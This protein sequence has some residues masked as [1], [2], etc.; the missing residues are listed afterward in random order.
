MKGKLIKWLS[1][2]LCAFMV[3]AC[4]C[5]CGNTP[6]STGNGGQVGNEQGGNEQGGNE[7]GGGHEHSY[8]TAWSKDE[9]YHWHKCTGAS[10]TEIADKAKHSFG[11]DGKCVCGAEKPVEKP[12]LVWTNAIQDPNFDYGFGVM[13]QRD[14][15]AQVYGY[16]RPEGYTTG[17]AVWNAAQWYSGYYH[18]P[19]HDTFTE[20]PAE[21]NILNAER[22]VEGTR[23]SYTD[24][25]KTFAFDNKTG[26]IYMEL[27]ASKEY[28]APRTA[29]GPW[30]HLLIQYTMQKKTQLSKF[31]G[32]QI[33][34]DYK[35]EKIENK[36]TSAEYNSGR[37]AAQLVWYIVVKNCN[38][39][40][41][42][43]GKYIWFGI[44]MYDNRDT[45]LNQT[46]SYFIDTGSDD[47]LGT[48]APIYGVAN[49]K[50]HKKLP[51]VGEN[52]SISID[53]YDMIKSAYD[54][55]VSAGYLRDSE[56]SDMYVTDGNCGWELPGTFD[57]ATTITK[58]EINT[59]KIKA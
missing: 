39:Y 16:F 15:N 6:D 56:W 17:K 53:I 41:T 35:L 49:G 40:S 38:E 46:D 45:V 1:F 22:Q 12:E 18:M 37:H 28:T 43:N 34:L 25:S 26:E 19:N 5:G 7:P 59:G 13:G 21:Y 52:I 10:C 51:A 31:A 32:L 11:T 57:C 30:P 27:N 33:N 36:M 55:A 48:G 50:T 29:T 44:D 54:R 20:Y 47:K 14:G 8:A 2:V 9:E 4:L 58:F 23:V 24:A 3:F 42:D